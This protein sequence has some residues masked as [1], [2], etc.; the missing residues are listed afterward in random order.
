MMRKVVALVGFVALCQVVAGLGAAATFPNIE[1][2]YE[3]LARPSWGP[4]NWL[5]GP[6][7]TTLYTLMGLS[8]FMLWRE[9][10]SSPKVRL[11]LA[12]FAVQLAL[13]AAWSWIFFYARQLGW[14]FVDIV[15]L[16]IALVAW[17]VAAWRV[18]RAAGAVNLFYLAWVTFAA[19]L[20]FAIWKMN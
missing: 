7:W 6:V 13:N 2:W 5:F 10:T 14:A 4:P 12:L 17:I 20:N 9:G 1:P 18:S 11:A 16:W 19:S 3:H 8:A 15:A